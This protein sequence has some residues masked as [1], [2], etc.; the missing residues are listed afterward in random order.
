[1]K[2]IIIIA[3]I[4]AVSY[5]YYMHGQRKKTRRAIVPEILAGELKMQDVVGYL[6]TLELKKDVDTPFIADLHHPSVKDSLRLDIDTT[7]AKRA[8][9]V[10][11]YKESQTANL[12]N[13]KVIFCDSV[14]PKIDE[15]MK[16]SGS[17][18]GIIVLG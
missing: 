7:D 5:L 12:E 16:S 18:S 3:V 11:T 17:D 10:A 6:K 8:F 15:A 2:V 9:I 1:M 14:E 4:C 13:V